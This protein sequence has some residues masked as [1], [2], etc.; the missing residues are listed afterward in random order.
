MLY[1]ALAMPL[2]PVAAPT[3]AQESLM[4]AATPTIASIEARR[5]M[6]PLLV[7]MNMNGFGR[8]ATALNG[9]EV[10]RY[11]QQF[12]CIQLQSQ[13]EYGYLLQ[14]ASPGT[15]NHIAFASPDG[16]LLLRVGGFMRPKDL[17]RIFRR[18]QLSF[19]GSSPL[20]WQAMSAIAQGRDA[21]ADTLLRQCEQQDPTAYADL[22]GAQ[23]DEMRIRGDQAAS[24]PYYQLA[25]GAS[26]SPAERLCW[27]VRLASAKIRTG[28]REGGLDFLKKLRTQEDFD[29]EDQGFLEMFIDRFESGPR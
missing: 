3:I 21:D 19:S 24:L 11:A 28:D 16:K 5:Q 4:W 27:G 26:R 20:T 29:A 17:E 15:A 2:L 10:R 13:Q 22:S 1:F 25:F 23:G 6:R 14:G 18:V 8:Y 12:Q 9:P 7:V